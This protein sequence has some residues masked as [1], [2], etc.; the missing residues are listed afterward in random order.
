M[1]NF[2]LQCSVMLDLLPLTKEYNGENSKKYNLIWKGKLAL[3]L[4]YSDLKL[5]VTNIAST[6]VDTVGCKVG[7]LE[8]LCSSQV[9]N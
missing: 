1:C 6:Y 5:N 9:S 3:L 8:I 7:P 2:S 4:L